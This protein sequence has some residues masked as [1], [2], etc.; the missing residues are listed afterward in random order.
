MT[1]KTKVKTDLFNPSRGR[2]SRGYILI[3]IYL[4]MEYIFEYFDFNISEHLS[5]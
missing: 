4:Y 3:Y 5:R 2:C 1:S